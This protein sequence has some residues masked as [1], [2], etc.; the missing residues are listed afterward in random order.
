LKKMDHVAVTVK[1]VTK[2]FNQITKSLSKWRRTG[3]WSPIEI[4]NLYRS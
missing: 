1:L 2:C 3:I 4:C